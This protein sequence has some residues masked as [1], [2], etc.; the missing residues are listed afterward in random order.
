MG[1]IDLS[2]CGLKLRCMRGFCRGVT[3]LGSAAGLLTACGHSDRNP[4]TGDGRRSR[5]RASVAGADGVAPPLPSELGLAL[6]VPADSDGQVILVA[7]DMSADLASV[8]GPVVLMGRDGHSQRQ[9]IDNAVLKDSACVIASVRGPGAKL[10]P[11]TFGV[12]AD[13]AVSLPADSLASFGRA[14]SLDL[15]RRMTALAST[16]PGDTA[17]R[18]TGLPFVLLSLW[19]SSVPGG[20]MVVIATY[21]RQIP[22]EA[23]PLEERTLVIAERDGSGELQT[24]YSERD[25]GEEETVEATEFLGMLL[26]KAGGQPMIVLARDAG[27]GVGYGLLER[28]ASPG[29][30]DARLL[31]ES[32]T[33][34]LKWSGRPRS[35]RSRD[36]CSSAPPLPE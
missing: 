30:V 9:R 20:R 18:F 3:V 4:I 14:D 27:D 34:L 32:G 2:R 25:D 24:V 16:V 13:S 6:V 23:S 7:G 12:L 5:L 28:S 15:A 31:G 10:L 17:N 1:V 36:L 33:A 26:V 21:R 35:S 29:P 8:R 11:F 22:M 19:R